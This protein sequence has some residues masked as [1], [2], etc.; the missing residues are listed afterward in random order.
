MIEFEIKLGNTLNALNKVAEGIMLVGDKAT[1]LISKLQKPIDWGAMGQGAVMLNNFAQNMQRSADAI[2]GFMAPGIAFEQKMAEVSAGT[3]VT[4]KELEAMS[5]QARKLA[6]DM[7]LSADQVGSTYL[8]MLSRLSP[9]LAKTEAGQKALNEMV[10]TTS[11][12]SKGMGGDVA[13]ASDALTTMMNAYNIDMSKPDEAA[14]KMAAIADM[15]TVSF[16]EGAVDVGPLAAAMK[17]LGASGSA[18]N[19]SLAETL[20][21][22]QILGQKGAKVGAEGGTAMRNVLAQLAQGELMPKQ[23]LELLKAA[24]VNISAL[25]D[26]TKSFAD[27]MEALK[28]IMK[29]DAL[30]SEFFGKENL[31]AGQAILQ[32]L[33][34]I[35]EATAKTQNATGANAEYAGVVMNTTQGVLDRM[36][37]AFTDLAIS[38]YDSLKPY[39]P[40]ISLTSQLAVGVSSIL[41][42]FSTMG[43][44]LR[45]TAGGI[46]SNVFGITTMNGVLAFNQKSLLGA[47][48]G[49]ARWAGTMIVNGV[50]SL[51]LFLAQL[52]ATTAGTWLFNAALSANPIGLVVI[53]VG[54]LIGALYGL[55]KVFDYFGIGIGEIYNFVKEY[56]PFSLLAKAIDYVFGTSLMKSINGFFSWVEEKISWLWN[57]IKGLGEILGFTSEEI[58][59]KQAETAGKP[60]YDTKELEKMLPQGVD[61]GKIN[62]NKFTDIFGAGSETSKLPDFSKGKEKTQKGLS[63]VAGG[64]AK[65]TNITINLQKLQDKIEVHSV[66]IKEGA[67][68]IEKQLTEMLFRVLNSTNQYRAG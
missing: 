54:V 52:G 43:Q 18:A 65:A 39:V 5:K 67:K 21:T 30:M 22:L 36:K 59:K 62:V 51:G 26:K 61:M 17:T 60:L 1:N 27:R 56:N 11:M 23:T 14:R 55:Y 40:M 64:G 6:I 25:T 66:N 32:N 58:D 16:K 53:G 31:V 8:D 34:Q 41:P 57:K 9:E 10:K 3:G 28:P 47:T 38:A 49:L 37:S 29:N 2:M 19:V 20:G 68:D 15:L 12:L 50:A 4:G 44:M 45:A 24:G 46:L 63:G 48:L 33:D 35:R 42:L 7:G 13:G